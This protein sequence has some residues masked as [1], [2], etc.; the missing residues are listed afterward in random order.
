LAIGSVDKEIKTSSDG[1][2]ELAFREKK[3]CEGVGV[4]EG[5]DTA[6]KTAPSSANADRAE[7]VEVGFVFVQ[8]K[9]T[10]ISQWFGYTWGD[11]VVDDEA[12]DLSKGMEAGL[13]V[14]LA[15]GGESI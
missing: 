12:E 14:G 8:S 7:F 1:K 11:V 6:G 10:A 5:E 9:E 4:G 13:R 3:F 2:S 15:W